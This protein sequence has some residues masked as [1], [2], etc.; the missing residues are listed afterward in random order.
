MGRPENLPKSPPVDSEAVTV[1]WEEAIAKTQTSEFSSSL[2][3]V[4]AETE[5]SAGMT[6]RLRRS[7][8]EQQRRRSARTATPRT[9]I[10]GRVAMLEKENA[11]IKAELAQ[12]KQRLERGETSPVVS[13]VEAGRITEA[14]QLVALL[15]QA[16][17][18]PALE[19]WS[20]VIAQPVVHSEAQATGSSFARNAEW[21]RHNSEAHAGKWVALRDGTLVDE[22]AS[23]VALQRRLEQA[24]ALEGITF[25]RL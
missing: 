13:L 2:R 16:S 22:G 10:E 4:G 15:T 7:R 14:R 5:L 24:N 1:S 19:R 12:V 6:L 21:L 9:T 8:D 20:Q 25:V 18:T 3:M 11:A 23:R 17:P